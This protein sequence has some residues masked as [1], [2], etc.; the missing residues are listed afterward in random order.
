MDNIKISEN[1][2]STIYNPINISEIKNLSNEKNNINFEDKQLN[3]IFV[4]RL[5]TQKNIIYLIKIIKNL[6]LSNLKLRII[7]NGKCF[8]NIINTIKKYKLTHTVEIIDFKKNTYTYMRNS[9]LFLLTSKW[10][11]FGHVIAESLILDTPVISINTKGI[12][13]I[14]YKCKPPSY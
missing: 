12:A 3:L 2:I 14:F 9:D 10:E 8:L 6:N 7:G 11:G 4:G 13:K 5:S 1:K